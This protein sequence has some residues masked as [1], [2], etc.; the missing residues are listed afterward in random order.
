MMR[1]HNQPMLAF[2]LVFFC[3]VLKLGRSQEPPPSKMVEEIRAALNEIDPYLPGVEIAAE[4]DLFG[5]T[6]MDTMAHGSR[7]HWHVVSPCNRRRYG[8]A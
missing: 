7:R 1:F 8:K 4:V 5:S 3:S 2:A 6:S